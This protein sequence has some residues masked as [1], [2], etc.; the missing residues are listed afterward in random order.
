M[1]TPAT[2]G[3]TVL[4][5]IE[6]AFWCATSR[7]RPEG[8][9]RG[10]R[11]AT[12]GQFRRPGDTADRRDVRGPRPGDDRPEPGDRSDH[13]GRRRQGPRWTGAWRVL[14]AGP[15]GLLR[16]ACHHGHHRDHRSHAGRPAAHRS[17]PAGADRVPARQR[18]GRP[19]RPVRHALPVCHAAAACLPPAGRPGGG[20]GRGGPSHPPGRGAQ[21]S[22][23]HAGRPCPLPHDARAPGAPGRARHPGRAP[24]AAGTRGVAGGHDPGGPAGIRAVHLGPRVPPH[25]PG[26]GCP[27]RPGGVSVPRCPRGG[28]VRG[29]DR[30]P[31]DPAAPLLRW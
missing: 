28:P 20:H 26:Q 8:R 30:G 23:V 3:H 27:R 17:R 13:G 2:T 4:L 9:S 5:H 29:D 21:L 6:R 14:H 31:A 12:P 7:F 24:H 22:P 25:P 10:A 18:A 11:P 19:Q 15:P 1:T 16:T